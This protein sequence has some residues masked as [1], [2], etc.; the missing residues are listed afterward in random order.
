[1]R[2]AFLAKVRFDVSPDT[3]VEEGLSPAS[4]ELSAADYF[5]LRTMGRIPHW[6]LKLAGARR[7]FAAKARQLV[8]SASGLCLVAAPDGA[9]STDVCVGRAMQRAWL[10][11][12]AHGLAVQPMMSLPVL[13]NALDHGTPQLQASLGRD[14]VLALGDEFRALVPEV[15]GGRPAFLMRFGFAPAPS[16][17]TGRLPLSAVT[18]AGGSESLLGKDAVG[19]MP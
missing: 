6:L 5:A 8:R 15:G 11:L 16:G 1:M 17:R 19:A 4:L 18:T 3:P 9:A 10:I 12:T 13:A 14:K 2:R 7:V